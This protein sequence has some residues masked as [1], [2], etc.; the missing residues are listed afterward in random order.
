MPVCYLISAVLFF[1]CLA[2]PSSAQDS[3]EHSASNDNLKVPGGHFELNWKS[4]FNAQEKKKIE[5]WLSH[6]ANTT[7][8]INGRFPLSRT[9][10]NINR[11]TSG[12]SAVPWAHTL[13]ES[14]P[15]GVEFHVDPSAS[16]KSFVSDWTAVH[17]FSHLYIPFPGN[18]DLWMSEG[19]A[20]YYQNILMARGGILS[21]KQAWQ[22]LAD[23]FHRGSRDR[24]NNSKLHSLSAKRSGGTMR[25]YWSGALYF[26][27]ADLNLRSSGQ[28][29]DD[30]ISKYVNCCRNRKKYT[31]GRTLAKE[32]DNI[33]G[34]NVF[35]SLYEGYANEYSFRDYKSVL[36]KLGITL[37]KHHQV[38]LLVDDYHS[39]LRE[40]FINPALQISYK[41][42]E[43]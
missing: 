5:N 41:T 19:F 38:S 7:S 16:L 4:P 14:T 36:T 24:K 18:R 29:L 13:R 26:L 42:T 28:S 2:L 37:D 34:R 22:K 1:T 33:A 27:E 32:F 17:E 10:I 40:S 12:Q 6:A 21:E 23:G 30:I 8:L 11:T 9:R 39:R 3:A 15:E 20:S 31:N 25:V 35:L 43:N